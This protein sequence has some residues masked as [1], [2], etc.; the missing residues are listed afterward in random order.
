MSPVLSTFR[1]FLFLGTRSRK[2]S[3]CSSHPKPPLQMT[4]CAPGRVRVKQSRTLRS[5]PLMSSACLLSVEKL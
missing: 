5:L 3:Q 1:P 4:Q 2:G